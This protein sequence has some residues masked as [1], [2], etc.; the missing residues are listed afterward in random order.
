MPG[1]ISGGAWGYRLPANGQQAAR[2]IRS[3]HCPD[4]SARSSRWFF[5]GRPVADEGSQDQAGFAATLIIARVL[6]QVSAGSSGEATAAVSGIMRI[7]L[8][9]AGR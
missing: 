7:A 8:G 4:P 2:G 5:G 1:A 9:G 3:G 6:A